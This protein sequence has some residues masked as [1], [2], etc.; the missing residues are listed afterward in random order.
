AFLIVGPRYSCLDWSKWNL[1]SVSPGVPCVT[2]SG[3][4]EQVQLRVQRPS[5][6][7]TTCC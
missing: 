5:T 2:E 7:P 4:S 3:P 1:T 6:P